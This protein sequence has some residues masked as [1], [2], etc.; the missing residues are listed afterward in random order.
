MIVEK[1]K[2]D[3]LG[4][5]HYLDTDNDGKPDEVWFI[6][7]DP[8]HN[9]RHRPILVRVIDENNN[10]EYSKEPDKHGDL[11]VADWN[12]DGLVDAVIG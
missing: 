7:T 3:T 12:A 4:K 8:R 5:R 6:D 1:V 11:W 2:N 10:L 9:D